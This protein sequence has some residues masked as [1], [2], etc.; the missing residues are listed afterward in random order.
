MILAAGIGFV[1]E[2][3]TSLQYAILPAVFIGMFVA[4]LV[5]AKGGCAVKLKQPPAA[6]EAQPTDAGSGSQPTP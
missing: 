4:M 1:V 3:T 5:P 6:P 2:A